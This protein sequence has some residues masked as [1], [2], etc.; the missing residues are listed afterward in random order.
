MKHSKIVI[1]LACSV[2][3]CGLTRLTLQ[4]KQSNQPETGLTQPNSAP[5]QVAEN[6]ERPELQMQEV[7]MLIAAAAQK[8]GVPVALVKGIVAT[9]SNFRSNVVSSAGAVGLMQLMPSTARGYGANPNVPE[10]NVDAGTRHLRFL[11]DK[12]RHARSPLKFAIAA[13]NAGH[14]AVDRYRGIPPFR[15]TRQYVKRVLARMQQ[16]RS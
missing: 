3:T 15:E 1:L 14:A 6:K 16:F 11:I 8:H 5:Q 2:S 9:E 12:Y 10:Q 13:Y 4:L 7:H